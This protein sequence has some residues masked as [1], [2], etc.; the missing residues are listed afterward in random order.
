MKYLLI[1]L[2]F[3]IG[4]TSVDKPIVNSDVKPGPATCQASDF[5]KLQDKKIQDIFF[6]QLDSTRRIRSRPSRVG[7]TTR[8]N[9]S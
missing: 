9:V 7:D 8:G 5:L 3:A 2:F 1:I 6:R 4:C